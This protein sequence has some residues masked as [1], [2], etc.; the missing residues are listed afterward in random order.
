MSVPVR[1]RVVEVAADL[2]EN[3]YP[4]WRYGS[5][6]L[7]GGQTV[8]TAAHVVVDAV[9]ATIRDTDK[10]HRSTVLD[11]AFIGDPD[12]LDLA[13]LEV[14]GF[15]ASLPRLHVGV[16]DRNSTTGKYIEDCWSVGYPAFQEI[17]DGDDRAFRE[18]AHVWGR[19]PPLRAHDVACEG[20]V[21][22]M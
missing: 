22:V 17:G 5:G 7:I 15:G 8:L 9:A 2:G 20:V 16:V 18:T 19:I 10:R 4:R 11:P 12:Q 6:L 13:L 1:E 14:P 3:S 21:G